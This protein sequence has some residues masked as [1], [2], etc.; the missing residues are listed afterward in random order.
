M[1]WPFGS[2]FGWHQHSS[3][4]RFNYFP[5]IYPRCYSHASF[6]VADP[7]FKVFSA[8]IVRVVFCEKSVASVFRHLARIPFRF[9]VFGHLISAAVARSI[10]SVRGNCLGSSGSIHKGFFTAS[11]GRKLGVVSIRNRISSDLFG[12]ILL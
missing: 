4:S 10:S 8:L 9:Q 7:W 1:Q 3:C 11:F 12:S 5:V 2:C 6:S